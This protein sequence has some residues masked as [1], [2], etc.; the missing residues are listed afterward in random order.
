LKNL[1]LSV[2]SI[3]GLILNG[4]GPIQLVAVIAFSVSAVRLQPITAK[5]NDLCQHSV[6]KSAQCRMIVM[7]AIS[8]EVLCQFRQRMESFIGTATE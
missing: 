7:Y 2:A 5:L 6:V 4:V 1:L 8:A 3:G